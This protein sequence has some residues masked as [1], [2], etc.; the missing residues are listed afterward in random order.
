MIELTQANPSSEIDLSLSK[1]SILQ[2]NFQGNFTTDSY[3]EIS[4][5][6]SNHELCEFVP[7]LDKSG[8]VDNQFISIKV[9]TIGAVSLN[10]FVRQGII[11]L[12][13]K[14]ATINTNI[15]VFSS[16]NI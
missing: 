8:D 13:L 3:I 6:I 16:Y 9:K 10:G 14:N 2:L 11:K 12:E 15:K 5:K 4:H 7:F 1:N